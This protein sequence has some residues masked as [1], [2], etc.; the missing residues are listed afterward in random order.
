MSRP[1]TAQ[2]FQKNGKLTFAQEKLNGSTSWNAEL[3]A[4]VFG[5]PLPGIDMPSSTSSEP[6][7]P[8]D[9]VAVCRDSR[10]RSD[11]SC[12]GTRDGL[13]YQCYH[14][15]KEERIS[16]EAELDV[17]RLRG[18]TQA[19]RLVKVAAALALWLAVP[20]AAS[21][22]DDLTLLK[23]D[24]TGRP[25]QVRDEGDNW[26]I[27]ISVYSDQDVE[28]Y[29]S[30]MLTL[31]GIVWDGAEFQKDGTYRTYLYSFYKN[32]HECRQHRIP[33]GH[34]TDPKWLEACTIE[35]LLKLMA[36]DGIC[37]PK[38]RIIG[39]R[40]I[41]RQSCR[42]VFESAGPIRKTA[43]PVMAGPR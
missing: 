30:D 24:P 7:A 20:V 2:P 3:I 8:L 25:A 33:A 35:I 18:M 9:R 5:P 39:V 32:D 14:F 12:E 42:R 27:P 22:Q 31:A 17:R 21:S 41:E 23:A 43:K 40:L 1:G 34:E 6:G 38:H 15:R 16:S 11:N 29:L 13:G 36:K 10:E 19:L 28:L 4:V 37:E 26:N